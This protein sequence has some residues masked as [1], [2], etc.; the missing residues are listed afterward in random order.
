M[1]KNSKRLA[2]NVFFAIYNDKKFVVFSM[3]LA[4][5]KAAFKQDIGNVEEIEFDGGYTEV[6]FI[7]KK[8]KE[9]DKND[10]FKH[11]EQ[12]KITD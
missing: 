4:I 7:P 8:G 5:F 3:F 2:E 6:I 9:F 12:I 1:N 11:F 10:L